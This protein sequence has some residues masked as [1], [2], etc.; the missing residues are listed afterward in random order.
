MSQTLVS[1]AA[2]VMP[3]RLFALGQT[4]PP[5]GTRFPPDQRAGWLK[6]AEAILIDA[7]PET[8]AA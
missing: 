1:Q 2:G 4:L 5:A 3:S 6:Y 7:Y 8:K